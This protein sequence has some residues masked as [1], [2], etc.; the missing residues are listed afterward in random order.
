[1]KNCVLYCAGASGS[2]VGPS[3]KAQRKKAKTFDGAVVGYIG[4]EIIL[5]TILEVK[6]HPA[7]YS[8]SLW[9]T[10][11]AILAFFSRVQKM[12]LKKGLRRTETRCVRRSCAPIK[13]IKR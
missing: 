6:M 9:A 8:D 4:F 12:I 13:V 5:A 2:R 1:M 10:W 3:R 11:M 7:S